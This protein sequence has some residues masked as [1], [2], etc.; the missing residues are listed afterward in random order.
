[1][2]SFKQLKLSLKTILQIQPKWSQKRGGPWNGLSSWKKKKRSFT[3]C[4][5]RD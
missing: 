4:W 3:K 5:T 2:I 1:M